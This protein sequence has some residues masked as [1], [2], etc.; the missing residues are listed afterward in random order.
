M[1]TVTEQIVI[2]KAIYGWNLAC[3]PIRSDLEFVKRIKE[4]VSEDVYLER[5]VC[6]RMR[7]QQRIRQNAVDA[8]VENLKRNWEKIV[9]CSDFEALYET[10]FNT[11]AKP[12]NGKRT[13]ISHCTVYDTS[14][15]IGYSLENCI[16]P[17]KYVYVHQHLIKEAVE[18][19]GERSIKTN[20]RYR[21]LRN[22]FTEKDIGF[23]HLSSLE[24]EDFL[25]LSPLLKNIK[26]KN[27]LSL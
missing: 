1:R 13:W 12:I 14:I 4:Y 18:L 22:D 19:L 26:T 17:D 23:E 21:L 11:I 9:L 3:S 6:N 8:A 5:C 25:C 27:K 2:Y 24:I 20:G 15:R 10:V 7:H 16:L